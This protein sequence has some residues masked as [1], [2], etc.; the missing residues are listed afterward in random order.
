[1]LKIPRL[2]LIL[3]A[4]LTLTAGSVHS[5]LTGG[6]HPLADPADNFG[7]SLGPFGS[8]FAAAW[9]LVVAAAFVFACGSLRARPGS[10]LGDRR[11]PIALTA[12]VVGLL[13]LDH[14]LLMLLGYLPMIIGLVV[15]G[16]GG[17]LADLASPGLAIQVSVAISI[18]TLLLALRASVTREAGPVTEVELA[19]ATRRTRRWTKIAIE[20]PL[21]YALTRVLMYFEVPGFTAPGIDL[22]VRLAGLGLAVAAVFGAVLTW[23]LIRPWGERFP[24]WMI[25]LAGRRVPIDLAVLPALA[26]AGLVLAASRAIAV[27]AF[28]AGSDGWREQLEAPLIAVPQLL[29]PLWGVA[30]ALAALAYQRRRRIADR[31]GNTESMALSPRSSREGEPHDLTAWKR[32]VSGTCSPWRASF[33][34]WWAPRLQC[35]SS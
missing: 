18:V 24:R 13:T 17:T 20:A 22:E 31:L 34:T 8:G 25:G 9:C 15:T 11:R 10:W 14:T 33:W 19:E 3:L 7:Q 32:S 35:S 12:G 5:L 16:R 23:G 30:L 28:A 26:V 27:G 29:W 6:L 4:P 2:V 21:V 1:M